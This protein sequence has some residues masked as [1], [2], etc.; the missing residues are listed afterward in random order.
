MLL[1]ACE[2]EQ[3][4]HEIVD[5]KNT[6]KA[7][8]DV[9]IEYL[10]E[11]IDDS[12]D[13]SANYIKLTELYENQQK[14]TEKR[15]LLLKARRET[16]EDPEILVALGKIYLENND[17]EELSPILRSI[18]EKDPENLGFL[19]L[20]AGYALLKNDYENAVFFANRGLLINP[21]DDEC[22]Y[23]LGEAKL[24]GKDSLSALE[25]FREAYALQNSRKNFDK[26][27][28]TAVALKEAEEART[29]L[30]KF[31]QHMPELETCYYW[32]MYY[33]RINQKDSARMVLSGCRPE[34]PR[35]V[36]VDFELA[37]TYYP[38]QPDSVFYY[39]DR[40]LKTSPEDVQALVL[41]AK[42]LENMKYYTD[43][44]KIFQLAIKIDSTSTLAREGLNNLD[45]KVAYLRLKQRKENVKKEFES[46]KP[47][48][49][50]EIN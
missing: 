36:V 17:A 4:S 6:A 2:Q 46:L 29:Y 38:S 37:R 1:A 43:A 8:E 40:Y 39:L 41:K 11:E 26:V 14:S 49:S 20:S 13:V 48:N 10:L 5:L 12:P 47:L 16:N 7:S 28:E 50:K 33:N 24:M 25:I 35:S 34:A 3:G 44:R 27:F 18:Q 9:Y 15:R 32:G 23:L 19:K 22:V 31:E 42:T 21:Y 30:E 45:R